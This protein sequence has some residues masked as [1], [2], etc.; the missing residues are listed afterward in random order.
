M[1]TKDLLPTLYQNFIHLSRYARW[2]EDLNRRE[3]WS[4]TVNRYF[5]FMVDYIKDTYDVTLSPSE[6]KKLEDAVISLDVMPSMRALMTAGKA[7]ERD[8]IAGFNC[9]YLHVNRLRAFDETLYMLMCGTGVGFSVERQFIAE[10]P[11]VPDDLEDSDTVINVA[12]SKLG[13]AKAYREL[14]SLLYAG[15]I[16]KWDVS[17]IRPSGARLRTFGG[18]ASGPGP[19]EEL[20]QFTINT[21]RHAQGRRLNSIEC[22]DLMCKV[23]DVVVVGGVRRS[24]LIS[25]SNLTD[26]R[27]R[28][29]KSGRWWEDNPQRAL[30]NNS[31][32]YTERP[33]IGI[34]MQEWIALYQSKSGER[35]VFSRMAAKK[36]VSSLGEERRNPN[37]DFGTN[38]CSEI[39]LR[40]REYCNLTEVV[41]RAD[42]TKDTLEEKVRLATILGTFQSTLTDFRYVSSE[43]QKNCDEERLLGVS[44]TG[45]MDN[46]LLNGTKSKDKLPELLRSLRQVAI[47]TNKEWAKKLGVNPSASITCVKPSGTVSQL[48]DSASGI[49]ARHSEYYIRTVRADKKDPLTEFMVESGF[50]HEDESLKPDYTTVFSFPQKAPKSAVF[51]NDRAS[52]EQL[53]MWLI[54]YHHWCEHKPSVTISVKEQEWFEVGAWVYKHFDEVSGVSFLPYSEHTYKQAPYQECTKEEYEALLARMPKDVDWMKL[55]NYEKQDMTSSVQDLACA[56]GGCEVL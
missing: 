53:E 46:A 45:I 41:V 37:Y 17:R 49:H 5:S 1:T 44:L 30:A 21:F 29:A 26:E 14:L 33:D 16:P 2:S 15:Q 4:E 23:G 22:H 47:K 35:G 54:Y 18:R 25:L 51:R 36:K 10:L 12:D 52:I 11:I 32:T 43:W 31:V 3:T 42:D 19:L 24:A 40:D 50:P 9:A 56:A 28:M 39:I 27:M 8:H 6:R 20:F 13:W 55:S 48:V 34:F 38:P 7:L